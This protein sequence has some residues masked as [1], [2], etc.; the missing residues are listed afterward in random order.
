MARPKEMSMVDEETKRRIL[1]DYE[2]DDMMTVLNKDP[3]YEYYFC[4][5]DPRNPASI[6]RSKARGY[7]IVDQ[8]N[9]SGEVVPMADQSDA[10]KGAIT[11][12]GLALMRIPKEY[13]EIRMQ[14]HAEEIAKRTS[15][16]QAEF[17]EQVEAYRRDEGRGESRTFI[18]GSGQS[19]LRGGL[20]L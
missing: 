18:M 5:T 12:P 7:E 9:N 13:H 2:A 11:M 20:N 15:M 10:S 6:E 3:G 19:N 8:N 17:E 14:R 1:S 4:S 16:A